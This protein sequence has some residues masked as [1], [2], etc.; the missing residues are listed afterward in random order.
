MKSFDR[1][2]FASVLERDSLTC[3]NLDRTE[4]VGKVF[5]LLRGCEVVFQWTFN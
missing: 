5:M 2:L 1:A 3:E 4:I